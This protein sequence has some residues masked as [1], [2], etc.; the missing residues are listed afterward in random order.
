MK[1][2]EQKFDFINKALLESVAQITEMTKSDHPAAA[3]RA[4]SAD[5]MVMLLPL[6]DGSKPEVAKQYY[7]RF[8]QYIKFQTK[9]GNIREPVAEAIE[10]FEHT[11]DKKA[12]GW[13]QEHKDK[14]VDLTTLKTMFLQRYNPWG[15]TKQDQL[16]SWNILIFDPQKTDVDEHI[17][18]INTLGDM[19]GQTEESKMEKFIDTMP[20]I[21]QTHLITCKTW[22][23][24]TKKVKELVHIIRKCDPLAAV[25]PNLTKGT[26]VPSLYSH[27]AHSDDKEETVIPQSFKGAQPKQSKPRGGGK[28][29]QPQQKPKILQYRYK[30]INTIM[31]IL[32]IITTMKIIEVNLEDVDLTE[33][34]IQVNFSEVK[35][36]MA[37]VNAIK[38][39]TKANIKTMVIKAIIT[40]AIKVYII[41]HIEISNRVILMA[42]LE[43]EAMVMA[44]VITMAVVMAGP[45]IEVILTTNTIS[46]MVMMM[47][48]RQINMVHHAHY[49][50]AIITPLNI[51]LS[52]NTISMILWKR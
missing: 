29:K 9:S 33:A 21:I 24:T 6:F 23:K 18:L 46:I 52:E 37:E 28:G 44:K 30:T 43:A 8:N 36:C 49:A 1:Q 48:T 39:H 4:K 34:K 2:Y 25:L 5:K 42:N 15:K 13:F 7:E 45:I 40:K 32:I 12:L 19:L 17:D 27:I 31:M 16:Q 47:S 41:I 3:T 10:L 50:V 26:A 14:F 20:T 38:M 22:V 11:L 35:I 51:V